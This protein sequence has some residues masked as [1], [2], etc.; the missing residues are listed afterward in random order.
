[1][2]SIIVSLKLQGYSVIKYTTNFRKLCYNLNDGFIY[3]GEA[4][5]IRIK[6]A[7]QL[8][9]LLNTIFLAVFL[10]NSPICFAENIYYKDGKTIN[11]QIIYHN[12]DTIWIKNDSG[13]TGID[14]KNV[15]KIENDDGTASK[16]DAAY[17]VNQIQEFV[18]QE[19]YIEAERT[20]SLLLELSPEDAK[21]R[22]LRGMLNQK[23]GNTSKAAEDYN[24][25]I[26]HKD[27][28]STILNNLGAI[29][30]KEKRYKDAT[31]LFAQAIKY[32]PDKAEF[33]NNLSELL[34]NLK[35]YDRAIEEYNKV[36]ELEP[37]NPAALF[38]LGIAYKNKGDYTRAKE[39]WQRVLAL[40]PE[41]IEAKNALLLLKSQN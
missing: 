23:I 30:A 21:V 41:D 32:D 26:S 36:L 22:Y 17:L 18:K 31:D 8:L 28:D 13:S 4:V 29:Y 33:H 5:G 34:M 27:A 6:P 37:D 20:C 39:Q 10:F 25:L 19:N 40:K 7:T 3:Q 35:D 9:L 24:F 15:S 2:N 1:M 38:N 11:A 16:Y 12:K 14:M